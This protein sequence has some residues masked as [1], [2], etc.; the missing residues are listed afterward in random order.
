MGN[1]REKKEMRRELKYKVYTQYPKGDEIRY[2]INDPKAVVPI[3]IIQR[4]KT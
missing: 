3:Q 1:K 2:D 4:S